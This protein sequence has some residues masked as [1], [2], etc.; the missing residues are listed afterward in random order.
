MQKLH[1]KNL[2]LVGFTLFSMF[3]G[4]G[5]LIFPPFLGAQAGTHTWLAMIGMMLS[6]IG[7]PVLGVI[8]VAKADGLRNLAGR[9]HPTFAAVF[10]LLIY[11]SI[12][13]GLAIPRTASTSFEMV[14]PLIGNSGALQLGYSIAFFVIALIIALRPDKLTDRLGKILCPILITLIVVLF[15][16]CL[17]HPVASSYGAPQAIYATL[18][19]T[20]GF[21]SG[22]DTMDTIAAL[23]FGAIIALNIRTKG[24]EDNKQ[25]V[26]GTIRAGWIAGA[27][28]LVIY[29]MLAHI[30][31][32][33]GAAFPGGE[34]G[35]DTLTNITPALFGAPGSILL[36]A[37]FMIACLNTCIGLL[38][39]CSDYFHALI[40][41]VSY[42]VWVVFFAGISAVISNVG[43]SGILQFSKPVLSAIYPVALVL[44]LLSLV[45]K[46]HQW[47]LVYPLT[48]GFVTVQSVIA[49]LSQTAV[50]LPLVTDLMAKIPLTAQGFGW[51]LPGVVGLLLGLILC[52]PTA[53]EKA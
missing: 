48:I 29:A 40:P 41:A 14:A 5:N 49:A 28:M 22:Y 30:G 31:A 35:A 23:N 53:E 52:R 25:I 3:F 42:R 32:L 34:T 26:R 16:G 19:V 12:G 6:A 47:R 9:V 38:S 20:Q 17:V 1:G 2:L 46:L 21:I 15:I 10:T 51:I 36:A 13:P 11:L 7:F 33:S 44:I 45:P 8:A 50:R 4:A 18:P 39:C 43:L 27:L 37:I 24:I